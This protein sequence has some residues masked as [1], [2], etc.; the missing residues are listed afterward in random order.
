MEYAQIEDPKAKKKE[1]FEIAHSK[2]FK[3][4]SQNNRTELQRDDQNKKP[5]MTEPEK[6]AL[7]VQKARIDEVIRDT[8]SA[9]SRY[10]GASHARTAE[11]RTEL[12]ALFNQHMGKVKN[13]EGAETLQNT[14]AQK[15]D[16]YD[17]STSGSIR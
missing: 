15:I 10:Q 12:T 9:I 3:G 5:P 4:G 2:G 7:N 1:A 6:Q 11:R 13:I 17:R 8:M 16:S 14:I